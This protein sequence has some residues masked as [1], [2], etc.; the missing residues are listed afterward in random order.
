[1]AT[2][3]WEPAEGADFG[4][5]RPVRLRVSALDEADT[6]VSGAVA[7]RVEGRR[8][9]S[10]V[11][12]DVEAGVTRLRFVS[13]TG[14]GEVID[15][16]DRAVAVP[17]YSAV[18]LGIAPPVYLQARSRVELA[19]LRRGAEGTPAAEH[20]FR[21]SDLV[22]VRFTPHGSEAG[23]A[24]VSAELQSRQGQR[25]LELKVDP[26]GAAGAAHV[27]LPLRSLS[28]GQYVLRLTARAGAHATTQSSAFAIV[29]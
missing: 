22:I 6:E 2:V 5:A 24:E 18:A 8:G 25:L 28:L 4:G 27:E 11:S 20:S 9:P 15:R 7:E 29:R 17:D 16:W 14:E 12:F 21:A 26:P 1:V 10:A 13:E 3:A 19:E 23:S